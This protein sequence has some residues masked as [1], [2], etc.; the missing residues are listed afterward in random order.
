[1]VTR[2]VTGDLLDFVLTSLSRALL[3][4]SLSVP[5]ELALDRIIALIVRLFALTRSSL[6]LGPQTFV[7]GL[8]KRRHRALLTGL[9]VRPTSFEL[10]RRGPSRASKILIRSI[11]LFMKKGIRAIGVRLALSGFTPTILR[12]YPSTTGKFCLNTRGLS[13]YF[14]D[15]R[16]RMIIAH[17]AIVKCCSIFQLFLDRRAASFL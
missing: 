8:R 16:G 11:A 15:F 17:L 5:L 9:I 13:A 2:V 3:R 4:H 10:I 7:M 6:R 14:G 12:I 1:M